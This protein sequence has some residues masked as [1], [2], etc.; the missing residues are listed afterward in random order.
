MLKK[1]VILSEPLAIH[2]MELAKFFPESQCREPT[3]QRPSASIYNPSNNYRAILTF[4]GHEGAYTTIGSEL[5]P[6]AL[7]LALKALPDTYFEHIKALLAGT[8]LELPVLTPQQIRNHAN[9][10]AEASAT[11]QKLDRVNAIGQTR[12][13]GH[14][15]A[16]EAR[17]IMQ[18][19]AGF[20]DATSKRPIMASYGAG[21]CIIMAIHNPDQKSV[22]L[23][24]IDSLTTMDSV[25]NLFFVLCNGKSPLEVHLRGG[26]KASPHLAI[27]LLEMIDSQ[28]DTLLKS[29]CLCAEDGNS[30]MLAIDSRSGEIFTDFDIANIDI[31]KDYLYRKTIM[32]S[33]RIPSGLSTSFNDLTNM[34]ESGNAFPVIEDPVTMLDKDQK[35]WGK[36]IQESSRP[37]PGL[38]LF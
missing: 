11:L 30:K 10:T 3:P 7:A 34:R 35:N 28:P 12:T 21:P 24:H 27:Q 5:S 26:E 33:Q 13:T 18:H 1:T 25:R 4:D 23:A 16:Q 2:I 17:D 15:T 36:T 29:A 38:N 6:A 9:Q 19:S 37:S 14:F 32:Q 22:A 20:T 8:E 31:G